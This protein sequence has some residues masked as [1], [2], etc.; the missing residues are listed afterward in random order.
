VAK[1]FFVHHIFSS[2]FLFLSRVFPLSL[3]FFFFF[4][5]KDFLPVSFFLLMVFSLSF[6]EYEF[7]S[8]F[9]SFFFFLKKNNNKSRVFSLSFQGCFEIFPRVDSFLSEGA[10]RFFR[11]LTPFLFKGALI[12]F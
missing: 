7:P 8:F 4:F 11:G 6:R 5:V 9:C 12:F 1:Y 2:Y 10:L 3:F